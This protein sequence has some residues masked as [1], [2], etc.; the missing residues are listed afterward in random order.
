[1]KNRNIK[2]MTV[3]L[4]AFLGSLLG[5]SA[6]ERPGGDAASKTPPAEPKGGVLE[7]KHLTEKQATER[8]Q[9]KGPKAMPIERS[10]YLG[11]G[12]E[13]SSEALLTHLNL[14]SGLLLKTIDPTSPAGLAGL[15]EFDIIVSIDEQLLNG[16]ESLRVY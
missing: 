14:E 5:L 4:S 11:V 15:K 10:A 12:G 16:Q 7:G 3:G 1:M 13:P 6:I 8:Q 2:V 9:N